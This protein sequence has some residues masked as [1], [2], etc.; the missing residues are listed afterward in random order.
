MDE[1]ALLKEFRL[2]DAVPNGARDRHGERSPLPGRV[3][4]AH[5]DASSSRSRL[6]ERRSSPAPHTPSRTS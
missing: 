1:L 6:L 3:N 4:G 2:E 5:T